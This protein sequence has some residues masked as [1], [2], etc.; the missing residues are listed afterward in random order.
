M[1][2][3]KILISILLMKTQQAIPLCFPCLFQQVT[4]ERRTSVNDLIFHLDSINCP[5]ILTGILYCN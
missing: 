3:E 4:Q 2:P 1:K 5:Q